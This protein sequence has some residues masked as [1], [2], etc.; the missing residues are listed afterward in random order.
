MSLWA[1]GFLLIAC[2]LLSALSFHAYRNGGGKKFLA[3]GIVLMIVFVVAAV[4]MGAVLLLVSGI[5]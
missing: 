3:G 1:A 4:Y 2:A 5:K